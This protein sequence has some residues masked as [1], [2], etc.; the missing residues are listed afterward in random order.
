[1]AHEQATALPDVRV[2]INDDSGVVYMNAVDFVSVVTD[3]SRDE[4]LALVTRAARQTELKLLQHKFNGEAEETPII[5][6]ERAVRLLPF[7]G[8]R[9][10]PRRRRV[11]TMLQDLAKFAQSLEARPRPLL[12]QF[13][14]TVGRWW[15]RR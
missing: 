15:Q 9:D 12:V 2:A 1:M 14:E 6:Y 11:T 8:F 7:M 3:R 4:A 10:G 13:D 5:T